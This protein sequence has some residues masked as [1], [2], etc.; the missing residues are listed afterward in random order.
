MSEQ[1]PIYHQPRLP[2]IDEL[3]NAPSTSFWLRS[4]LQAALQR[5]P[6]DAANDAEVLAAVLARRR[7]VAGGGGKQDG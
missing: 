6:A 1:I 5:D 2:D 3:L 7:D 4:A